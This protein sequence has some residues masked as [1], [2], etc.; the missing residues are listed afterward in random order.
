VGNQFKVGCGTRLKFSGPD[1]DRAQLPRLDTYYLQSAV[2]F[3]QP[4]GWK[5][6]G[7]IDLRRQL[8]EF[9]SRYH[10]GG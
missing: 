4:L 2:W 9:R 3:K 10:Q 7:Y 1:A 5:T 8:R 6:Q